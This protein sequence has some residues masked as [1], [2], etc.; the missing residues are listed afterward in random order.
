MSAPPKSLLGKA[1]GY[2][3]REALLPQHIDPQSLI[4]PA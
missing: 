4:I 2:A 3:Q 1:I